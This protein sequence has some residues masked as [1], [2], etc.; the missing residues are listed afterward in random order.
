M[1]RGVAR[2]FQRAG[3]TESNIIVTA[4]SPR[5]IV[6]CFLKKTLTKGGVT[7]TP[8]R[9]LATPLMLGMSHRLYLLANFVICMKKE[10]FGEL[11]SCRKSVWLTIVFN[12][13][14]LEEEPYRIVLFSLGFRILS[15]AITIPQ[16]IEISHE[17]QVPR[18]IRTPLILF[19]D[20]KFQFLS[21]SR[22]RPS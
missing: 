4:F 2:I 9:P 12:C 3:H 11:W 22:S 13:G 15:E 19:G 1:L 10:Y 17:I 7:G 5:N 8:E 14:E 16:V 6:G 20:R 18:F 21:E